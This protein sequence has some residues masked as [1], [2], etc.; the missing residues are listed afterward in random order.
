MAPTIT[1]HCQQDIPM[2]NSN[3][4]QYIDYEPRSIAQHGSDF[5]E[6]D[7]HL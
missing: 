4:L 2:A 3:S 7:K 1:C 5:T 6:L